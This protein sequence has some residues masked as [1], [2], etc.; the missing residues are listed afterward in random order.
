MWKVIKKQF[1]IQS[2]DWVRLALVIPGSTLFG[3]LLH[4]FMVRND[5]E[6]EYYVA[7]GTLLAC[8]MAVLLSAIMILGQFVVY[9]NTEV[10][11]GCLRKHFLVSFYLVSF[12][13]TLAYM[14]VIIVMNL[15][16]NALCRRMYP[17]LS[18][19]IDF[20]PYILKW[21]V[22]VIAVLCIVG[23]FSSILLLRF[24][25]K[26]FWILWVIWMFGCVGIPRVSEAMEDAPNSLMGRIGS[27]VTG[28]LRG[29]P[30]NIMIGTAAAVSVF[31][32][33]MSWIFIR[34]Q[35]VS[36]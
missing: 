8:I 13:F 4:Y 1:A 5:S 14:A 20:L 9:F 2:M 22:P 25:R 21:G 12:V 24:G 29:I 6:A 26:A 27:A 3:M 31:C 32:M 16:E 34:K 23:I 19:E 17:Y 7:I 30:L 11:M 18:S 15:I 10:S 36:S 35:Q 28:Y 33:I